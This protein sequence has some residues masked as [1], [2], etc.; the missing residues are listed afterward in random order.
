MRKVLF[1]MMVSLDGFFEGPNHSIDW[2][3]VDE[4]FNTFANAQLDTVENTFIWPGNLRVDGSLLADPQTQPKTT[5]WLP[6]K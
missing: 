6:G 4:E 5:R 3:N 1:F 2:H